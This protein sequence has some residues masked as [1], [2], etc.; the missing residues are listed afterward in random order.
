MSFPYYIAKRYLFSKSSNN[1]INIITKVAGAGVIIGSAS[2][3]I[4]LS[5]F[6]GLKDF[7]IQF[8]SLIDPDLKVIAANG[9]TFELLPSD[10]KKLNEID[11]IA[12]FSQ[13]VEDRVVMNSENKNLIVALK[14]VDQN[15]PTSSIDSI[16]VQGNWM[17]PGYD[18]LVSGWGISTNLSFSVFDFG[19]TIKLYVP[20]PGKGQITSVEGAYNTINAVNSGIF[21]INETLDNSVVFANIDM[22]KRL[23]NYSDTQITGVEIIL[24]NPEQIAVVTEKLASIFED[25]V[26]IKNKI[27]LNDALYKMLNTENMAVYLIFTLVL[28][29]ALFNVIG[30]IIMMILDK[31]TNLTTLFNM[32]VTVKEIRKIFFIQGSL[33]SMIGGVIGLGLGILLI[34]LQKVFSLVMLTPSLP[35][36]VSL[37][38]INVLIVILTI[39]ILGILAS[40]VATARISKQLVNAS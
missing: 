8:S 33:M 37:R 23:L 14:G 22:V 2:L 32:G 10:L 38:P 3:F 36:P 11:E 26:V 16:I 21:Q 28:I 34:W 24:S 31:R 4:V 27:Q 18:Q 30:S 39:S 13:I 5:G 25:K 6:A 35:Y 12:S 1:A 29:I 7:S 20:K 9:K 19:K 17:E 15:Y 40:K